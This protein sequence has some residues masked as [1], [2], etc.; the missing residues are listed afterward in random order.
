MVPLP[1][2]MIINRRF[3]NHA[4]SLFSRRKQSLLTRNRIFGS[5]HTFLCVNNR[6]IFEYLQQY[7]TKKFYLL[8]LFGALSIPLA[9]LA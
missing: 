3:C 6:D 1:S 8:S 9:A 7:L 5:R 4:N 2:R